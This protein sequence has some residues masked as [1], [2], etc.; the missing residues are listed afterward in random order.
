MTVPQVEFS[1]APY[2]LSGTVY[3]TLLNHRPALAQLGDAVNASPYKAAPKAPVLYVKPRNTLNVHGGVVVAP[4]S[5]SSLQVGAAL[6]LVVGKT[7]CA[8]SESEALQFLAGYTVVTDFSVP[9][10]S[11]YRP[12]VRFKALN[13]SCVIGPAVVECKAVENPNALSVKVWLDDALVQSA[14]TGDMVRDAARL[15]A[16]VSEFMTLS[17]GDVLLLG[18]AAG[19]PLASPGQRVRVQIE[20]VGTQ[21]SRVEQE[22]E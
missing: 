16:D 22:A 13:G 19:A 20:G 4:A 14:S 1:V 17:A 21:E 10:E 5:A 2:R 3:G 11:F 7:A 6:G 9:H 15:L 12:S 18:V 8:V